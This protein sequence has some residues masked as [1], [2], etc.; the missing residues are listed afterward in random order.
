MEEL[1]KTREDEQR[2]A[3]SAL[4]VQDV[5]FLGYHDLE[6]EVTLT[7]RAELALA[8]RRAQP[9]VLFTFDPWRK[10]GHEPADARVS[11]PFL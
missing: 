2:H 4:S 3:A 7:L 8:I 1:A 10:G 5:T 9:D 11:Y 6:V